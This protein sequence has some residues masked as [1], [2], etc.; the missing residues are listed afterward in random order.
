MDEE[1]LG[2]FMDKQAEEDKTEERFKAI[3]ENT[4][5]LKSQEAWVSSVTGDLQPYNKPSGEGTVSYA[6]NVLK[7]NRWPGAHTVS[8]NGKYFFIYV[9]DTVKRGADFFNP[10]EPPMVLEDPREPGEEPEPN[11]KEP[12]PPKEEG[13]EDDDDE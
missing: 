11:G 9:G 2:E 7:S 12:A 1:A 4:K 3:N 13:E 5:V 8:K 6:I 10:T